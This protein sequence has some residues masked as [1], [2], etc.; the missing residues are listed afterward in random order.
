[1]AMVTTISN[2]FF[3]SFLLQK[4]ILPD[5]A[6]MEPVLGGGEALINVTLTGASCGR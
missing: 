6:G 1:M 3:I 2:V 4:N 5:N